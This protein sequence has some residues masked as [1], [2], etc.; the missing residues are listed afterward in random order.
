MTG[1]PV[2]V[3]LGLSVAALGGYAALPVFW[4]L[5]TAF[6]SGTAAAGGIAL[7]NSIGNLGGFAG[8]YILGWLRDTTSGF[9]IGLFFLAA[10]V[11]VAGL[12]AWL[13]RGPTA[14]TASGLTVGI[15][16]KG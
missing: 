4:P 7:V 2:W 15:A 16:P 13:V 6:L 12:V 3:L 14:Q 5:P 10:I 8:P 1:N 11:A 9:T